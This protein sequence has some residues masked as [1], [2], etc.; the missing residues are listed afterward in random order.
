MLVEP[1]ILGTAPFYKPLTKSLEKYA[2]AHRM[3]K[4]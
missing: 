2:D 3:R 1:V 4:K